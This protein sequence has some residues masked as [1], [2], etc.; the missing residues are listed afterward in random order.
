MFPYLYET[1]CRSP[2]NKLSHS[3]TINFDFTDLLKKTILRINSQFD[4]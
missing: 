3:F 4:D 2:L 1:L